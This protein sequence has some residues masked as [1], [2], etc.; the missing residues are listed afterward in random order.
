MIQIID[1]MIVV[2]YFNSKYSYLKTLLH[3][4]SIRSIDRTYQF[5]NIF[6]FFEIFIFY[7]KIQ[8]DQWYENLFIKDI[9]EFQN[10][11]ETIIEVKRLKIE[12]N[13]KK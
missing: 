12:R 4:L 13:I 10:Y 7:D 11:S 1:I 9:I 3:D 6:W 5:E 8:I 2:W